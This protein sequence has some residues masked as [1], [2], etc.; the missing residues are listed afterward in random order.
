MERENLRS[1][2]AVMYLLSALLLVLNLPLLGAKDSK[3]KPEELVAKH[4]DSIGTP[5]ARAA[6]KNRVA[7]GASQF[8]MRLP[9]GRQLS[10]PATVVSEGK[11]L[12]I[13]MMFGAQDYPSEQLIFDG[14][15]VNVS[16]IRPGRRSE[17]GG[18]FY[19][20]DVLLREGLIGGTMTTAWALLDVSER[21]AKLDYNGL[22]KVDGKQMH[23]L[24]YRAKKESGYLT[25]SLHFDPET[26]R[27]VHSEYKLTLP[28]NMGGSPEDSSSFRET[29]YNIQE[30]F[31]DFE[32]VDSL[33]LPRAYKMTYSREGTGAT[34]LMEYKIVLSNILHNQTLDPK[35]FAIQ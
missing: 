1:S 5:E 28:A 2:R 17:P 10:G 19:Q 35:A 22:K 4:L 13:S 16:Q 30:W 20:Y 14:N 24:R 31:D 8:T 6:A 25:I 34:A 9:T 3:M 23:E 33:N 27:H 26:F 29:I 15:K 11:L 18:F 21:Q 7:I 32:T 12:R